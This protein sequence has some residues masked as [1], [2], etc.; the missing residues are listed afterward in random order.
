MN[1]TLSS[2]LIV[3]LPRSGT[4]WVGETLSSA[5]NT[6]Y[7]FEPD[8]EKLSPLAW[9]YKKELHRFPCLGANDE[10][11]SYRQLW[12]TILHG[13]V[14]KWRLNNATSLYLRRKSE[15]V[16]SHI[17]NKCGYIYL[18]ETMHRVGKAQRNPFEKQA[19]LEFFLH[20]IAGIKNIFPQKRRLIIK[21]VHS[22]FSLDW[23]AKNFSVNLLLVLR[24][25]YSLYASYKRLKMPDGFRNIAF[26]ERIQRDHP[27]F[28]FNSARSR[29]EE[30]NEP[31]AY[32]I[33]LMYKMLEKQMS[34]HPQWEYVSH[35]RLCIEPLQGYRRIF[36][37]QNLSWEGVETK[38][39]SLNQSGKD[40]APKRVSAQEPFKWKAE[41]SAEEKTMIDKWTDIFELNDFYQTYIYS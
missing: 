33:A 10:D 20:K 14:G 29:I 25:P 28:I 18:D 30:Q 23:I 36:E 15:R 9:L 1:K 24:N 21:S 19:G 40:F 27:E 7:L 4:T 37:N 17:G 6:D 31:I 16:E 12:Q 32:Q 5:S 13:G 8:N 39:A 22:I 11:A 3:G 2:I 38:I 34:V 35:D 26:Q 41:I